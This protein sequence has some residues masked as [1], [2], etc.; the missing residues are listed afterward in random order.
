MITGRKPMIFDI[1]APIGTKSGETKSR[2][3]RK[4]CREVEEG[5]KNGI[6]WKSTLNL[7]FITP[8]DHE[9]RGAYC[10]T[11]GSIITFK[12]YRLICDLIGAFVRCSS[13]G[14]LSGDNHLSNRNQS[15]RH[16]L[17]K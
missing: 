17:P 4:H 5:N 1:C 12:F 13:G 2:C 10:A 15:K 8:I 11:S 14:R 6:N 9:R 16:T 7:L 3:V